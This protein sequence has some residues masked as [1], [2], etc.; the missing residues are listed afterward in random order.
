[1]N[2]TLAHDSFTQMG[3][4]ERV[5]EAMHE[6]YPEAPVATLVVDG[7]YRD[8]LKNWKIQPSVLQPIYNIWPHFKHFLV[9]LTC[10]VRS[11][12][13]NNADIIISSS[14]LFLKGIRIPAGNIHIEYCH[15]PVRFL[16][17]EPEYLQQEV[18]WILRPLVRPYLA[19]LRRWDYNAAQ[20]VNYFIA[21]SKEVQKRI[22]QFY[23][24]EST[25][26]YPFI[27]TDFWRPTRAKQNYFLIAGRLQAHKDNDLI[28]Q[29]FNKLSLS[30]HVVGSGSH[31]KHLRSIAGP[32]ITFLGRL[33]DEGLRDEYS[34][35]QAFIFP[36]LEDF[37]IMPL[38]AA[39]CGTPT[40]G[41]AQGG[42]LETIVPGVTGE[43]LPEVTES[44]LTDTVK[45][46]NLQKYS[47]DA[48]RQ[49]GARFSKEIFQHN[50]QQF[51]NEAVV[52]HHIQ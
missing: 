10:G 13:F 27:D 47:V 14:S 1:M 30:L 36:Q 2:I 40:I 49:H 29:I 8:K 3:G 38:E 5:I 15:T 48:M 28:I 31:E 22:K 35:A 32:T 44:S 19:R 6:M 26:I 16:W 12:K 20:K 42:S 50:I 41:L 34:G 52:K 43:L 7:R 21:N 51:V 4:A 37:G 9:L 17:S 23:H 45:L 18:P 11:L 33:S 24:R 39:V 46:W 25:V